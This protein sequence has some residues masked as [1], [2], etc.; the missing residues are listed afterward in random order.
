MAHVFTYGSLMFSEVWEG[1]VEGR[2]AASEGTVSG[3]SCLGIVSETYPA[4]VPGDGVVEGVLYFDVN[5]K[6][7]QRLDRFEG[8]EYDRITLPVRR[9]DGTELP[10]ETYVF[11]SVLAHRLNGEAWCVDTFRTTG[12]RTFVSQYVGFSAVSDI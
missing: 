6:D 9:G 7:L 11:K 1:V 3:Y 2:Y 4:L 8:D 12:I 5:E 10:A